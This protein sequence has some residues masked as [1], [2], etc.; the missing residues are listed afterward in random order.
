SRERARE[1]RGR[2]AAPRERPQHPGCDDVFLAHVLLAAEDAL[3]EGDRARHPTRVARLD[4]RSPACQDA[5]VPDVP[6][7][8]WEMLREQADEALSRSSAWRRT[9]HW[10]IDVLQEEL[11]DSW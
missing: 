5:N 10:T 3:L 11:G 2:P 6:L 4:A 9:V 7:P 1:T 8:S